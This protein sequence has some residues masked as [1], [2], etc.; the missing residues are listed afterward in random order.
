VGIKVGE[1]KGRADKH[2]YG[3]GS[4]FERG[5]VGRSIVIPEWTDLCLPVNNYT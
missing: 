3:G 1:R 2:T 5:R 4:W